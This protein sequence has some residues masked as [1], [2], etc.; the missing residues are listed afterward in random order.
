LFNYD[1]IRSASYQLKTGYFSFLLK[2]TFPILCFAFSACRS[3][4]DPA[5]DSLDLL[6]GQ[7][8]ERESNKRNRILELET[9]LQKT[10]DI[11]LRLP[12]IRDLCLEYKSYS[13]DS[14]ARYSLQYRNEAIQAGSKTELVKAVTLHSYILLSA[15][16]L[17]QALDSLIRIPVHGV[18][19][20]IRAEY[21]FTISKGYFEYLNF[22]QERSLFAS[23]QSKGKAYL[24]SAILCTKENSIQNLSFRGLRALKSG[25]LSEARSIYERLVSRKDLPQRQLA[26]EAACL[27]S[28]YEQLNE[29]EKSLRYYIVSAKT[30]ET[31]VVKEYASLIRI[32]LILFEKGDLERANRYINQ[33]LA[34]ANFFGSSQRKIQILEILP[35]I[36]AQQIR[37]DNEKQ[38][39][40]IVFIVTL[41]FL[42]CGCFW[43]VLIHI[44]QNR[45][46]RKN[47][48]RLEFFNLDLGRK[49]AELEEAQKIKENYVRHFFQSHT[50]VI[51]KI[52]K[53]LKD[54]ELAVKNKNLSEVKFHAA[55]F[56]PEQEK[57]KLL[58]DFDM[59]FL[60][61]FPGFV[62]EMNA[63]LDKD[64][65]FVPEDDKSL[66][67]ELRIFALIRMGIHSNEVIAR[68]LGY[69]VNTVYT[70]KTKVR[71]KSSLTSEEFDKAVLDIQSIKD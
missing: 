25:D 71:N 19:P 51:V 14:A 64:Q 27:A 12:I 41:F 50:R 68:T 47:E 39:Q 63:L 34:D 40:L 6:L 56:K 67:T 31:F 61:I 57:K 17:D 33:A 21:Y 69:S 49:N 9:R 29:T 42:L 30:D 59:A 70:Y 62:K 32:A 38:F 7:R 11:S 45:Q 16:I 52:E 43:L 35:L 54:I 26:I 36:K 55:Q 60:D 37:L 53:I 10:S 3:S 8:G 4:S 48:E 24:D 65:P 1:F 13:F 46:I 15:G 5:L 20:E 2:I 23:C 66:N 18:S 28:T 58:K 44:R 22:R